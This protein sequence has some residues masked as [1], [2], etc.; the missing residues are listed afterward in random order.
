MLYGQGHQTVL[1]FMIYVKFSYEVRL[2]G[3]IGT[4]VWGQ[5]F[6]TL[7]EWKNYS[8]SPFFILL[9]FFIDN[10]NDL[11]LHVYQY[12]NKLGEEALCRTDPGIFLTEN[13]VK[14][15]FLV[16]YTGVVW[17]LPSLAHIIS[18]CTNENKSLSKEA[19]ELRVSIVRSAGNLRKKLLLSCGNRGKD[20]INSYIV[21][22]HQGV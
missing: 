1:K 11:T 10:C 20:V 13:G 6:C 15:K 2:A 18:F 12:P 3:S 8:V 21:L 9:V 4:F 17:G 5:I 14:W 22:Q 7:G 16:V 19:C